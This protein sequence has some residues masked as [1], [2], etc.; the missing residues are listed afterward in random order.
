MYAN[1]FALRSVQKASPQEVIF[2]C[3]EPKWCKYEIFATNV[4]WEFFEISYTFIIQTPIKENIFGF[5][6]EK[7]R[8]YKQASVVHDKERDMQQS[9]SLHN[10]QG[11]SDICTPSRKY[12]K[13]TVYQILQ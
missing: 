2:S 1:Y 9:R 4:F 11:R 13:K 3:E 12:T 7:N 10:P 5:V 6:T 8:H